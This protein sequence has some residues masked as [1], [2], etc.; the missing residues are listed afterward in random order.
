MNDMFNTS[1]EQKDGSKLGI[2]I[3]A[4]GMEKHNEK[5]AY[6]TSIKSFWITLM[7]MLKLWSLKIAFRGPHIIS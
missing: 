3:F 6:P 7:H 4:N 1:I 5:L 2:A